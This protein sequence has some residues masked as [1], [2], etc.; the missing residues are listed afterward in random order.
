VRIAIIG[1]GQVG[2]ALGAAWLKRGHQV[3]Y[4]V[5]DA[6]DPRHADLNPAKVRTPTQAARG[7]DVIVIATP[8]D[9]AVD[10]VRSLGDL[11]GRII[12]DCT[13]PVATDASGLHLLDLPAGSGAQTLAAVAPGAFVFKTLNQTGAENITAAHSY[14]SPLAMFVAGD[15]AASKSRV[16][17]LVGDLGFEAADAGALASARLL[18][19][20]ALLWIDL[21]ANRGQ[22]RSFAFALLRPRS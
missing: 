9:A 6:S 22:S 16:L 12:I 21:A 18:E 17:R 4:G 2:R 15:D 3:R 10:V 1:A 14:S 13:N 11:T 8:W 7:A 19:S 20:L 5:R